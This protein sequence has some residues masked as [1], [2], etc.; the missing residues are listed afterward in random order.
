MA[1][2][3]LRAIQNEELGDRAASRSP[4]ADPNEIRRRAY[5]RLLQIGGC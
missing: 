4:N 3:F 5:K 2:P 1:H